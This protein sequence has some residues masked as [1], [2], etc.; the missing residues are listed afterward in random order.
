ML[1]RPALHMLDVLQQ[2]CSSPVMMTSIAA[3]AHMHTSPSCSYKE[4]EGCAAEDRL[5][6]FVNNRE[7]GG[8]WAGCSLLSTWQQYLA[9]AG[10]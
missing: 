10:R 4:A 7:L 6:S 1:L 3:W 2:M 5:V 8:S 9:S